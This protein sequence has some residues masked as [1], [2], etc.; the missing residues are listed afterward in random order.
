[1]EFLATL[2]SSEKNKEEEMKNVV[3]DNSKEVQDEK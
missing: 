1:L 2:N 3:E